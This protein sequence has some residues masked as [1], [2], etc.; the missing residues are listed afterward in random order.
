MSDVKVPK[1]LPYDHMGLVQINLLTS[2][3]NWPNNMS[4]HQSVGSTQS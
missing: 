4:E 1:N 2:G 3:I